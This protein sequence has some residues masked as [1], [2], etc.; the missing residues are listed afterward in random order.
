MKLSIF[1]LFRENLLGSNFKHQFYINCLSPDEKH[2]YNLLAKS[3]IILQYNDD[4]IC[5]E[6]YMKIIRCFEHIRRKF[7]KNIGLNDE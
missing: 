4:F 7:S 5:A 3:E 1:N 6:Q 2:K